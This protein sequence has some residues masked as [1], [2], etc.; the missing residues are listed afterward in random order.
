MKKESKKAQDEY[1]N[2]LAILEARNATLKKKIEVPVDEAKE[3]WD[4]FKL[5]FNR[6]MDEIG[7]SLSSSAQKNI[8]KLK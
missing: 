2:S 1:E 6:E 4:A 5:D 7:K 3:K 8:K